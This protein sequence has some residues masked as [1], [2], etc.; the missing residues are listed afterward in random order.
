MR[1]SDWSSVVCSSDL[2]RD[3]VLAEVVAIL[4]AD[5]DPRILPVENLRTKAESASQEVACRHGLRF[6][7]REAP[8]TRLRVILRVG[9]QITAVRDF[10]QFNL[11]PVNWVENVTGCGELRQRRLKH[12]RSEEHTHELQSLMR[13]SYA[14]FCLK[15]KKINKKKY[16][17]RLK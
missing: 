5:L 6:H 3:K 9:K 7:D 10:G 17:N 8:E 16:K 2:D 4:R 12:G 15:K 14:V 1:I 11:C 13:T